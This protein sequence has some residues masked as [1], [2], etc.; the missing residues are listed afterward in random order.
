M[1]PNPRDSP[2]RTLEKPEIG[3]RRWI[4]DFTKV[5]GESIKQTEK[6]E[7]FAGSDHS[8][9]F[10]SIASRM[11]GTTGE[12]VVNDVLEH[13]FPGRVAVFVD[14]D[15]SESGG[16][17]VLDQVQAYCWTVRCEKSWATFCSSHSLH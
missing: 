12:I 8:R 9:C 4:A 13:G 14:G 10:E 16:C 7:R 3:L 6:R 5:T 2:S 15:G 1:S 11:F 17:N